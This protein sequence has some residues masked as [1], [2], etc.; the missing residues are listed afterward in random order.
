MTA[1]L[2]ARPLA[3]VV[4]VSHESGDEIDGWLDAIERTG[5]RDRLELC[6]VDSGSG[7]RERERLRREVEPRVDHLLLSPTGVS[8]RRATAARRCTSAPVLIFTNPDTQLVTLPSA[9]G[10]DWP[11]GL[12]VGA[13][14][15][16][17][18]P[19]DAH[20]AR[21]LPTARRQALDLALGR[22]APPVFVR[23]AV[24]PTWV[25]GSA[26][27]LTRED[28]IRDGLFP[29]DLFLYYEDLDSLPGPRRAG[30]PGGHRSRLGDPPPAGG[31]RTAGPRLPGRH[32][33]GERAAG[34]RAPPGPRGRR[35]GRTSCWRRSTFRAERRESSPGG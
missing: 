16:S 5:M 20:G 30:R 22:F 12:L 15:H 19:P 11:S 21:G 18:K 2:Q 29:E 28:F 34:R 14:N 23:D 35:P 7:P 26:L 10:S 33:P 8:G 31:G 13:M 4:A 9:V 25:S 1:D 3:A 17:L 6:I 32:R 27:A 24:A